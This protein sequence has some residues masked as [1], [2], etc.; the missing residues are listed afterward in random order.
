M[1]DEFTPNDRKYINTLLAQKNQEST[2][3][4]IADKISK[5]KNKKPS[6]RI[7]LLTKHRVI[8]LKPGQT[9]VKKETHFLDIVEIKSSNA[10]EIIVVSKTFTYGLNTPKADDIINNIRLLFSQSYLGAPEDAGFKLDVKPSS[11]L[12]DIQPK[13][14]PCGGFVETYQFL[15][16]YYPST[17]VR[18]D[19]CWDMDHI[20]S[21][22]NIK[23]FNM[24]EIEQPISASD[25]KALLGA[26]KYNTYFKSL[27][28]NGIPMGKDQLTALADT[29]RTNST[30]EDLSM[31]NVGAKGDTLPIVAMTLG[32][33]KNIGLTSID[34]SHNPIEDKG[35]I[36]FSNYIGASPRGIASLDFSNT[37]MGKAGVSALSNALKKNVKM[38]SSLTYLNLSNN[39]ME[40]DGSAALANFL[41]NPNALRTLN[42]SNTLP[43]MET[44]VGA[45]VRGCLELRHLDLSDNRLTKKEVTHLVRF[46]GASATLKSINIS[47]TKVPVE[48]LKEL[49]VAI[50][51]N[52]YLQDINFDTKNN[53][54]GIAGA[55]ML[56]SLADKIPNI[57]VLDVSENDFGDEGVSVICEGFCQNNSV[58]RLV[59]NGNFKVSKTKSRP[60]AIESVVNLL[61][62]GTSLESLHMTNGTSKT[63]LKTE[64]LPIIY[65]LAT[66]DS[67]LELDISGHQMGNKGAIALGKALQT[68][69]ALNTLVWDDNMTGLAGFAGLQVGLERNLTLKNMPKPLVDIMQ[70]HRENPAKLTAIIKDIDYCINRNQAPLRK[71]ESSGS[72][73]GATNLAFLASGQQQ[74]IEKWLNK[75]K[76]VGRKTTDPEH[77][78]AIKDAENTEKVIGGMHLIKEAVHA[79]LE[80]E[81]NQKLKE[82]V[83]VVGEVVNKKKEEMLQ[84][85]LKTM[86]GTFQ[87]M[88]QSAYKRLATGIQYGSK[89]IDES[90]IESTLVKGAGAELSNK[91]HECF[92]SALEIA[93]DYTYEKIGNGLESVFQDLIHEENAAAAAASEGPETP[94]LGRAN[95]PSTPTSPTA[96]STTPTPVTPTPVAVAPAPAPAAVSNNVPPPVAPRTVGPPPTAP[97]TGIAAPGTGPQSPEVQVQKPPQPMFKVGTKVAANPALAAA[98]AKNIGGGG[99]PPM[100]RKP[101]AE[102]AP[103]PTPTPTPTPAAA[104]TKTTPSKPVVVKKDK[105][106]KKSSSAGAG[107]EISDAPESDAESL[108]HVTKSRPQV[109]HK[110]KPPTRRPAPP[111]S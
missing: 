89:D 18:L 7:I 36:P 43:T 96:P 55:R 87:S 14:L 21:V 4:G 16:D 106:P 57:S 69:K 39:K 76:S 93:S 100:F 98:I 110:R 77:V 23:T 90:G 70:A 72:G 104:P 30:I 13:E 105:D 12:G 45:L 60:S 78:V 81:L 75:I 102:P 85:I 2:Y 67:L 44:I 82:F 86:Q 109:Q 38:P 40:A 35:M 88:D 41:A 66:N 54:L 52:L 26:L 42:I 83:S 91:V 34:L 10:S 103:E 68:N 33:N 11:R 46:I 59:L 50:T 1:A 8:Y 61:E 101:A 108:S 65:S 47:N 99:A 22:R 37:S 79:S 84:Q 15:C 111:P 9:R 92:L 62:A 27:V 19:I 49:V 58:K 25:I 80:M 56:A 24:N 6:K 53:D 29:L 64:I 95:P 31:N 107:G 5:K 32:A 48:N 3:I 94:T 74:S 97:R 20:V 51:S 73:V 28:F 17:P 71:M 63:Q